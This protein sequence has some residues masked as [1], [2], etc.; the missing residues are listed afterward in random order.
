ML[1][2][3]SVPR[4]N[5]RRRV[6]SQSAGKMSRPALE[7]FRS[8]PVRQIAEGTC[9]MGCEPCALSECVSTWAYQSHPALDVTVIT[10]FA[11]RTMFLS[12]GS[13]LPQIGVQR[14]WGRSC[15]LGPPQGHSAVLCWRCC[16][17]VPSRLRRERKFRRHEHTPHHASLSR[18]VRSPSESSTFG[19]SCVISSCFVATTGITAGASL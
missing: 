2:G 4:P 11:W 16:P 18:P 8:R 5:R 13:N 7:N 12:S 19:S 3:K 14:S 15:L 1:S 10:S 9:A 6:V 17:A